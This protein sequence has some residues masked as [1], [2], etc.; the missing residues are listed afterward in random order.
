M[1]AN[2]HEIAKLILPGESLALEF[3]SDLKCL[4]GRD[5][6]ATVVSLAYRLL[7]KLKG[8]GVIVQMGKMRHAFYTRKS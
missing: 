2:E 7:K 4:P 1:N 3:K 8:E 6:V 5:L